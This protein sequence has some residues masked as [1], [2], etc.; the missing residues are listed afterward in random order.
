MSANISL[1]IYD[2]SGREVKSL[3][4]EFLNAGNHS[5]RWN[6]TDNFGQLVSS[7]VYIYTLTDGY[8]VN[9]QKMLF[10]K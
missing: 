4:S 3:V 5:F 8:N 2:I 10:M 1:K 9:S 7:G 6:G